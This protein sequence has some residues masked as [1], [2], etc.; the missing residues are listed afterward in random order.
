MQLFKNS[1]LSVIHNVFKYSPKNKNK[2]K[3]TQ[4]FL[5]LLLHP[6]QHRWPSLGMG[7]F[8]RLLALFLPYNYDRCGCLGAVQGSGA[9]WK[10]RWTSWA[11]RP[12]SVLTVSVDIK[13]HWRRWWCGES[14]GGRHR[15]PVPYDLCGRRAIFE[16][17]RVKQ[18]TYVREG[19]GGIFA[20]EATAKIA[21]KHN[22]TYLS[23]LTTQTWNS[24]T[25]TWRKTLNN[26]RNEAHWEWF[27]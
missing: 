8:C 7:Q 3:K 26:H 12:Q 9:V 25:R 21:I 15:T 4:L 23:P 2:M 13:Q 10:W 18:A 5:C 17:G 1:C 14:R 20:R 16:D 19:W 27:S 11:P 22:Y 6:L 24:T